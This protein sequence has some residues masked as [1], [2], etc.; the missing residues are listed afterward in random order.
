MASFTD[1]GKSLKKT[2]P[3]N[4]NVFSLVSINSTHFQKSPKKST[5]RE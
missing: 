5:H 4:P 1:V 3:E 2:T